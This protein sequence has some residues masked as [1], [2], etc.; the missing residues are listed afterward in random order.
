MIW[1]YHYFR[2]HPYIN[3]PFFHAWW[4][5][6][7]RPAQEIV[8]NT[9]CLERSDGSFPTSD[10]LVSW[11]WMQTVY[12]LLSGGFNSHVFFS[13]Q[14]WGRIHSFWSIVIL[15]FRFREGIKFAIWD[16]LDCGDLYLDAFPWF[17]FKPIWHIWQAK[18]RA[19]QKKTKKDKSM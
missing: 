13:L 9:N 6:L 19:E 5:G 8:G 11:I 15:F 14:T 17:M 2:K 7:K 1:G 10:D 3:D 16:I 4:F 18:K 12:Y